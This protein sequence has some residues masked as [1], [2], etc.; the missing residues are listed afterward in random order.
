VKTAV[1]NG[2]SVG[3]GGNELIASFLNRAA[4]D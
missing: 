3:I 1:G 4:T 2:F